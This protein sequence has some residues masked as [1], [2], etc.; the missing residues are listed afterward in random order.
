VGCWLAGWW[1]ERALLCHK[2]HS[3]RAPGYLLSL[4]AL[5]LVTL[6]AAGPLGL[7]NVWETFKG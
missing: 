1:W 3:L 2:R 7:M 4:L 6:L 5:L